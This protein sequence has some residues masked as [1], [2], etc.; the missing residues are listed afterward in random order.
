LPNGQ[1]FAGGLGIIVEGIASSFTL[2]NPNGSRDKTFNSQRG[3][4][5]PANDILVLDDDKILVL[6]GFTVYQ[7]SPVRFIARLDRDGSLDSSFDPG[8][9]FDNFVSSAFEQ[10][11]AKIVLAGGF[12]SY[13]GIPRNGIVR[14]N[15]DGSLDSSFDPGTGFD[16]GV[17]EMISL[18]NGQI[19]ASGPFQN[20]NGTSQNG[21]ARLNP[22]GSLDNSFAVGSGFNNQVTAMSLLPNNRYLIGGR[23]NNYNGEP[24]GPLVFLNADGSLRPNFIP[25]FPPGATVHSVAVQSDGKILLALDE[26]GQFQ[27]SSI[28][29]LNS[30]GSRDTSF[31]TFGLPNLFFQNPVVQSDGK[32]LLFGINTLSGVSNGLVRLN[33][34]GSL[35]TGFAESSTTG[36]SP[37]VLAL[38]SNGRIIVGGSFTAYDG[39]GRNRI[40]RLFGDPPS[41]EVRNTN[42]AGEGSLRQAILNANAQNGRD[43]ITFNIPGNGPHRIQ[44][45]SALPTLS[46]AVLIDGGT[47]P[48]ADCR[49]WPP[50]LMIELNG[51]LAGPANGLT[52][53]NLGSGSTIKGLVINGFSNH[54]I[55]AINADSNTFQCN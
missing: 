42:D 20:F 23:F 28:L 16:N 12:N 32:I 15:N 47:Q 51:D 1:I 17:F 33:S 37:F 3:F 5:R 52:I 48:G 18:P 14:I 46:E 50:T 53:N 8:T 39:I 41:L 26:K 54:A 10:S 43:T 44:P 29:R 40:T 22:D 19:L 25:N 49:V 35:D 21:L 24:V 11:N 4:N 38:Q 31:T 45:L 7:D 2:I 9:G 30:D 55:E 13:R 36:G 27:T 6:G 34:D